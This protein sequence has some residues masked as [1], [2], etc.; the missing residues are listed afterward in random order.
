MVE[1]QMAAGVDVTNDGEVS[2]PGYSRGSPLSGGI[3]GADAPHARDG[4]DRSPA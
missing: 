3:D 1:R 2:K 4:K